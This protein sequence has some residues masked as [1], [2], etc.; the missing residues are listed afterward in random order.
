MK[1]QYFGDKN[2]YIKYGLLKLLVQKSE[3]D[4]GVCWMLTAPD[5]RS[6]G[7]FRDYLRDPAWSRFD[8]DLHAKL[9]RLDQPGVERTVAHAEAWD[10][11]PRATY[12]TDILTDDM[13]GRDVYFH[14]AWPRSPS[15]RSSSSIRTTA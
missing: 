12:F 4:L 13:A 1:D 7:E 3:L 5:G 6:D 14:R 10:L 9:Q 8:P 15:A 2:D 11:L